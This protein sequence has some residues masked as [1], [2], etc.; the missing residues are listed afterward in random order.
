MYA[1]GWLN[2]FMAA[3]AATVAQKNPDSVVRCIENSGM[4][5]ATLTQILDTHIDKNSSHR[6]LP[7]GAVAFVAVEQW[8]MR[9]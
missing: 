1:T 8:C 2:G 7:L 4:V 6:R 5:G 9:K 3:K